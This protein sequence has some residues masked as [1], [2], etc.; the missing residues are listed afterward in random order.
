[1]PFKNYTK[2]LYSKELDKIK[3]SDYSKFTDINSPYSDFIE[4][5][6]SVIDTIAPVKETRIKNNSQDWSDEEIH[7][8]IELCDKLFAKFKRQGSIVMM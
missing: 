7:E 4:R 3:F 8:Q 6:T 1:M 5:L 2:D